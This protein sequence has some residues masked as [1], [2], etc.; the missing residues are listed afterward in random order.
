MNRAAATVP[1][2]LAAEPQYV[3][4]LGPVWAA[5][6]GEAQCWYVKEAAGLAWAALGCHAGRWQWPVPGPVVVASAQDFARARRGRVALM[7]HGC[8]QSYSGDRR[9]ARHPSYAGGVGKDAASLILAPNEYAAARWRERYPAVPVHVIGAT[10][11]L[12]PPEDPR[13][14]LLVVAFHWNGAVPELRSAWPHY[15]PHL[16]TLGLPLAL[17][18]H[19]RAARSVSAWAHRHGIEFVESLAEVARR[20]TVF[21]T[22]NSS[23]LWEL[24]LHRPVI[25]LNAPWYRR[26]V[27][28]GLRFWSHIPGPQVDDAA[29]LAREAAR[30]L[31]GEEEPAEASRRTAIV[32][33]VIPRL[34]GAAE[35]ARLIAAWA[36]EGA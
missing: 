19:P 14:R 12:I 29:G 31:A 13:A 30:L 27:H 6:D 1:Q 2:F 11:G 5:L 22:D 24:G 34:D 10:R 21:A 15:A 28:H 23:T 3:H 36:A 32:G 20:A 9:L 7:E 4:H 33:E 17:H 8:G 16:A 26:H 18:A 25:A 35:A